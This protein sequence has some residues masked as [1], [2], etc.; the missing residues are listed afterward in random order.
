ML[1][2]VSFPYMSPFIALHTVRLSVAK[3]RPRDLVS[4]VIYALACDT[5]FL[6]VAIFLTAFNAGSSS[7]TFSINGPN[8]S[9]KFLMRELEYERER[10]RDEERV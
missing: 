6:H 9:A 5:L 8:G 1:F 2:T 4:Q 3:Q 7:H 10:E